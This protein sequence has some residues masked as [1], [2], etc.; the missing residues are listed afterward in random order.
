MSS[1]Q[2]PGSCLTNQ[3][4]TTVSWRP[5]NLSSYT[6]APIFKFSRLILLS[7]SCREGRLYKIKSNYIAT[8]SPVKPYFAFTSPH[9]PYFHILHILNNTSPATDAKWLPFSMP[10]SC[11]HETAPISVSWTQFYIRDIVP[12]EHSDSEVRRL[13]IA[14]FSTSNLHFQ[15]KNY[16]V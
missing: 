4:P 9:F 2:R 15:G 1:I 13:R 16:A 10:Y 11:L 6:P 7:F 12:E 8:T 14:D 5:T 3:L